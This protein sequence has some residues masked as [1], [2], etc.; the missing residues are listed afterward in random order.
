MSVPGGGLKSLHNC[1]M[2]CTFHQDISLLGNIYLPSLI[3]F[4]NLNCSA[5]HQHYLQTAACMQLGGASSLF[6][7]WPSHHCVL[8]ACV[9]D[10]T[11]GRQSECAFAVTMHCR[12]IMNALI[13]FLSKGR[14]TS[15]LLIAMNIRQRTSKI[16]PRPHHEDPEGE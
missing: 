14:S 2:C 4:T 13:M 1:G 3:H 11:L 16:H 6:H 8:V 7:R 10:S 12:H 15:T 5:L 9:K